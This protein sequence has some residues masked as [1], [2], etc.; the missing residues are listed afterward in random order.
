MWGDIA[1]AFMIAFATAFMATPY[2]IRFAKKVGA[3]DTPQDPRR[4]NKVTMPRLG[5]LAV[6]LGFFLSI[7]Y[8]TI[9]LT[10]EKKIDIFQ[11]NLYMKLIGFVLGEI[12]I[13]IV[14]F[15]DDI[16]GTPA[17]IKLIFQIIAAII[18]V[19]FGIRI[20]FF[21]IGGFSIPMENILFYNI[22]SV[23]WIVGITNALNLIDG[24][25]GLST[26]ISIISC[27]S[28]LIIFALNDSP[29]IS[30]ILITSLCGALVGFLPYNFNP[31][32]T[33]IGDTGSNFLGYC[34]SIIS[35]LGI[36][37]TY[38]AIV[39]VAP[40]LVLALPLFDTIFAVIRRIIKGKN[41]KA[42]IEPDAG[43][44]HHKM[45]QKGFTQKQAVLTLYAFSASFGMFAIILLDSGIWKA[46]S[47]GIIMLVVISMG[48]K[49]FVKQKLLSDDCEEKQILNKE[50]IEDENSNK[51]F[52]NIEDIEKYRKMN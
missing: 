21:E 16:K 45:I 44:L 50:K 14:C 30:I 37:K 32:K 43:H 5:G 17:I 34:L 22:F 24:L 40:I 4:I 19:N 2:T 28:L 36:A 46:L 25:D 11:D 12:V 20:D 1:I 6:I 8:L 48:Y 49:E 29:L 42:V 27:I 35:I 18:V 47:F 13:G 3:V 31:A 41:L 33:F 39:V 23:L 15:Y 51:N 9:V 7:A 26:G 52:D 38:T 10:I